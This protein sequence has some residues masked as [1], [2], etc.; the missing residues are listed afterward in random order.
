[1][2]TFNL[3]ITIMVDDQDIGHFVSKKPVEVISIPGDYFFHREDHLFFFASNDD[4]ATAL[5]RATFLVQKALEKDFEIAQK[6]LAQ[7]SMVTTFGW[8]KK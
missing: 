6:K 7:I 3:S 8:N 5:H 4:E 1:M 2:R